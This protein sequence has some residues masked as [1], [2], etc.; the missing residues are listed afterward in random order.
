VLSDDDRSLDEIGACGSGERAP[1]T[2]TDDG[3][4]GSAG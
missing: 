4:E 1:A 2:Q 3:D